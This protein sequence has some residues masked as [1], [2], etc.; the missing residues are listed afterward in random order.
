L[1]AVLRG[2]NLVVEQIHER[3]GGVPLRMAPLILASTVLTHLVGGSAG[4]EGAAVQLGGSIAS[5]FTRLL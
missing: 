2:N 1:D 5:A 4:R 3:G